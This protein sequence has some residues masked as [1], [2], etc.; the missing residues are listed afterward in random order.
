MG[1]FWAK[2]VI[3]VGICS[4]S[5]RLISKW[6]GAVRASRSSHK[7]RSHLLRT[8]NDITGLTLVLTFITV[9]S[10]PGSRFYVRWIQ[11]QLERILLYLIRLFVQVLV[12][13]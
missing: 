1:S 11:S 9:T 2:P 12:Q 6:R 10:F 4:Q 3:E 5:M 13:S 8:P 7:A